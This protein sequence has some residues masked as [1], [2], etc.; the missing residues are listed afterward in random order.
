L[1]ASGMGPKKR[2]SGRK[3]IRKGGA[4]ERPVDVQNEERE[5]ALGRC[6][7]CLEALD[8][9]SVALPCSHVPAPTNFPT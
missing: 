6:P 7:L 2:V 3:K 9:T 1:V 4:V 5:E 8:A